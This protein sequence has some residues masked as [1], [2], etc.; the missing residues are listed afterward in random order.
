MEVLVGDRLSQS[1]ISIY[2]IQV[3]SRGVIKA[4]RPCRALNDWCQAD[5]S[6]NA[7]TERD[8]LVARLIDALDWPTGLI[9]AS[10]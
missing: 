8:A 6:G 2:G 3:C 10:Q 9:E 5:F 1:L 7:V 4:R